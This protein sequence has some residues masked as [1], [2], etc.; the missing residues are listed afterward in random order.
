MLILAGLFVVSY[1]SPNLPISNGFFIGNSAAS[2]CQCPTP[3]CP[4]VSAPANCQQIAPE[5]KRLKSMKKLKILRREISQQKHSNSN[6]DDE[7]LV[8]LII[9]FLNV[10]YLTYGNQQ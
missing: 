10:G 9:I 1:L 7:I 5:C 6:E 8:I 4:A 3:A 2:S